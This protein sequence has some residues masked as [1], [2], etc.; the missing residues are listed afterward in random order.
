[1][2]LIIDSHY[3]SLMFPFAISWAFRTKE[4]K[5]YSITLILILPTPRRFAAEWRKM[6]NVF[7]ASQNIASTCCWKTFEEIER[8]FKRNKL[9]VF[10]SIFSFSRYSFI[11]RNSFKVMFASDTCTLSTSFHETV[12]LGYCQPQFSHVM[13]QTNQS[14]S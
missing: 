1:M 5:I 4:W 11:P 9:L 6:L 8:T 13:Q 10:I 3:S 12:N 7:Y 14:I 2:N